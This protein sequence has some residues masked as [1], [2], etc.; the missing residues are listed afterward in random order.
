V[1]RF[2]E[3]FAGRLE[4]LAPPTKHLLQTGIQEEMNKLLFELKGGEGG[5][6]EMKFE[7]PVMPKTEYLK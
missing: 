1:A 7:E 3:E 5:N 4:G 6:G 2:K